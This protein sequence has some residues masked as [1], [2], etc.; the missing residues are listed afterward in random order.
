MTTQGLLSRFLCAWPASTAG[1]RMFREAAPESLYKLESFRRRLAEMIRSDPP[2]ERAV[3]TWTPEAKQIWVEHYNDV[4]VSLPTH[5][6]G[7]EWAGKAA[8][9]MARL[10]A[11]L[12]VWDDLGAREIDEAHAASA[13]ALALYYAKEAAR[14]ANRPS[15]EASHANR[16]W[17]WII[18][19]GLDRVTVRAL[20][21]SGP[22]PRDRAKVTAA[23]QELIESGRLIRDS[24]GGNALVVRPVQETG[25]DL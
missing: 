3:L 22:R 8:E 10:A 1:T 14:I 7:R 5:E 2:V 16:I 19:R 24:G 9:H 20:Q 12:T 4:E 18:Q 6:A 13:Y 15:P 21:Q 23:V 11:V 25:D 17:G